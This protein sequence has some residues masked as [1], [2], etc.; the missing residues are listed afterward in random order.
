M[1][2]DGETPTAQTAHGRA[3]LASAGTTIPVSG[4]VPG[5]APARPV[6]CRPPCRVRPA[7][8]HGQRSNTADTT[9]PEPGVDMARTR[10]ARP[11]HDPRHDTATTDTTRP[12]HDADTTRARHGH[13]T[14]RT[15]TTRWPRRWPLAMLAAP[16]GV[17]T[18]S[19]W[20]GL[21]GLTGFG[22]VHPL[23]G[24]ADHFS[25]NSAITLP[26]GVEAYAAYAMSAWL[27]SAPVAEKTRRF[28]RT[29]AIAALVLG[30]VR[31]GRVPPARRRQQR[32]GHRSSHARCRGAVVDHHAGRVPAGAGAGVR[33]GP[34]AH[35]P[36]GPRGRAD[37]RVRHGPCRV[38]GRVRHDGRHGR[39]H[40]PRHGPDTTRHGRRHAPS[41]ARHGRAPR[42]GHDPTRVG[43]V[44]P[45]RPQRRHGP[46]PTRPCPPQTRLSTR[47]TRH[48]PSPA[49]LPEPRRTRPPTRLARP[50][51]PTRTRPQRPPGPPP[52]TRPRHDP[53]A[54]RSAPPTRPTRP[55]ATRSPAKSTT[56][57][58]PSTASRPASPS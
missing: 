3:G 57:T 36:S 17:A 18:W 41:R 19:G 55:T 4:T 16:A 46:S 11:G 54:R 27:T 45:T 32:A 38:H 56:T 26:I 52:P 37:R 35:A 8:R 49:R 58:S 39:G 51:Q 28:A 44:C 42:R 50:A 31:P 2:I 25:I 24:I 47:P 10:H 43:V 6:S 21:G 23:P 30:S 7:T 33:R 22:V 1:A 40:G 13:D 53:A 48:G 34:G 5:A 20:V 29:S 15:D 9:R 12:A 14:A